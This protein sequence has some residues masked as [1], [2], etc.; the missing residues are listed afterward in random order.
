MHWWCREELRARALHRDEE[1]RVDDPAERLD[2][3]LEDL[4]P[5]A[6]ISLSDPNR[7]AAIAAL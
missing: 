1:G 3:H 2:E 5:A 7:E 6:P 4:T